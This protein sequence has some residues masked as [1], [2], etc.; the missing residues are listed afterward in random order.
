M[1]SRSTVAELLELLSMHGPSF[2]LSLDLNWKSVKFSGHQ[3]IDL[4]LHFLWRFV[5]NYNFQMVLTYFVLFLAVLGILM[6]LLF[7]FLTKFS[8]Q[9]L[10]QFLRLFIFF[11]LC[12]PIC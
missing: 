5:I 3:G 12:L 4:S 10:C 1:G 9:L 2:V 11:V 8:L 6:I 7:L